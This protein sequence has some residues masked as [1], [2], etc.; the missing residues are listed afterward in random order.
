MLSAPARQ[1]RLS[2]PTALAPLALG[3]L[4]VFG[5]CSPEKP[6]QVA[7]GEQG[8]QDAAD[9][10]PVALV[11]GETLT[12]GEM[13]RRIEGLTPFARSRYT[14]T[15]AKQEYL[16]TMVQFEVMADEAERRGLDKD[17]AVAQ[18]IKEAMV[19][20]LLTT[21]LK[22]R[23]KLRD[24]TDAEIEQ[25]YRNSLEDFR[26]PER[27][28]VTLLLVDSQEKAQQLH[29]EITG[30]VFEDPALRK[31]AFENLVRANSIHRS[32]AN[33]G[34][35]M[36]FVTTKEAEPSRKATAEAVFALANIGDI[37]S[38]HQTPRG[39]QIAMF[40]EVIEGKVRPLEEVSREIR[41]RLFEERRQGIRQ[42]FI[43]ELIAKASVETYP[44]VLETVE[45]KTGA[46][47]KRLEE[48]PK[49]PL[50]DLKPPKTPASPEAP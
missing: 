21:E 2:R 50:R 37:T 36:G 10:K 28:R 7:T 44:E 39:W 25:A 47:P 34:G 22:D 43:D 18:A 4:L 40:T 16:D 26:T 32:S 1:K 45:V 30:Q 31:A 27:R 12:V 17:P 33:Q 9:A 13:E 20:H 46:I 49:L 24:I 14:T 5:A 19:R 23:V 11:N 38:V 41:N 29:A 42:K 15:E 48:L 6:S 35:D 8:P 3:C